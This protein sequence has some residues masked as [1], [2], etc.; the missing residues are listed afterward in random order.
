[1]DLLP[2]QP[3]WARS[4]VLLKFNLGTF[5]GIEGPI[6]NGM[7]Q[8]REKPVIQQGLVRRIRGV[9]ENHSSLSSQFLLDLI[10]DL[11]TGVILLNMQFLVL[12]ARTID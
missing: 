1:M 7:C 10:G 6:S 2:V 11:V 8:V 12:Q 9:R 5:T 4:K 3:G